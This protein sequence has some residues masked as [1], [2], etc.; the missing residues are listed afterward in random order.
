MGLGLQ[1]ASCRRAMLGR[2]REMQRNGVGEREGRGAEEARVGERR[3]V[4]SARHDTGM[5]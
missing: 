3:V 5:W 2:E 1:G 4:Y